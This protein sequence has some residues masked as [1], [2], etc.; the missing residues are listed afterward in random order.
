MEEGLC[1]LQAELFALLG[2]EHLAGAAV[3]V[4]ANKQDLKDAMSVK[5]LSDALALHTI[6]RHDWHVQ[7]GTLSPGRILFRGI[8]TDCR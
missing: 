5:E 2:H 7:A 8:I 4:M 1:C 6:K 3:L